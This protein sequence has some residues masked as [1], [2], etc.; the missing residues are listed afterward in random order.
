MGSL[1]WRAD[2]HPQ[3]Y[4]REELRPRPS[5]WRRALFRRALAIGSVPSRTTKR[6]GGNLV[7]ESQIMHRISPALDVLGCCPRQRF[8]LHSLDASADAR[9]LLRLAI[10]HWPRTPTP[11][12]K[13]ARTYDSG[14]EW[15]AVRARSRSVRSGHRPRPSSP[16]CSEAPS[17]SAV[18]WWRVGGRPRFLDGRSCENA[19][20]RPHN[21]APRHRGEAIRSAPP[22]DPRIGTSSPLPKSRSPSSTPYR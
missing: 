21:S 8:A 14:H 22:R 11:R 7:S 6:M 4:R 13:S 18:R 2:Q 9:S 15:F 17:L 20:L 12:A 1:N 3:L 16:S 10:G 5:P 19:R